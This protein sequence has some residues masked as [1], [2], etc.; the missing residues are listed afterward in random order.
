M[1]FGT[2]ERQR[3]ANPL[4]KARPNQQAKGR[5][6]PQIISEYAAVRSL[7]S[8]QTPTLD[9]KKLLVES[10]RGVPWKEASEKHWLEGPLSVREVELFDRWLPVRRFSVFQ[11]GKVRPIDDMKENHLN[12]A[13]SSGEKID[14]HALDHTIWC[15]QAVTRF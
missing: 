7:L 15:L 11:R 3:V 13:F 10:W 2:L 5:G 9:S 14:L 6:V 8:T 12:Q 1:V 4:D